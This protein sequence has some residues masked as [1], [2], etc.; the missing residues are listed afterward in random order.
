MDG[1]RI[2]IWYSGTGEVIYDN[3]MGEPDDANLATALGG[4][5]VVIHE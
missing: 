4:G 2:K 1:V 3:Q 5:S